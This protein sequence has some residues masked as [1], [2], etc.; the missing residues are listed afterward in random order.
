MK[1]KALVFFTKHTLDFETN[2]YKAV[3]FAFLALRNITQMFLSGL[4]YV[5]FRLRV[6]HMDFLAMPY[7][8]IQQV[9]IKL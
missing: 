1:K 7:D 5:T 8:L 9:L 2:Q 6:K 3:W 4:I